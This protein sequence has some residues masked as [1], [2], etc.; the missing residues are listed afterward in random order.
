MGQY[1]FA[2][3]RLSSSVT[4]PVVGPAGEGMWKVSAPAARCEC[5]WVADTARR[6]SHVTSR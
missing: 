4:L 5:N 6:A 2:D 3:C 1:C